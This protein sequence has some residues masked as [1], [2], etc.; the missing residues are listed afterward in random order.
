MGHASPCL[1]LHEVFTD[2]KW[3]KGK[4]GVDQV[5]TEMGI[6]QSLDSF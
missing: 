4:F 1:F 6:F 3:R 2:P 5:G